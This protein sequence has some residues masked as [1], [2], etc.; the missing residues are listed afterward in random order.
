MNVT[1]RLN[2][3]LSRDMELYEPQTSIES[4]INLIIHPAR[5]I[6]TLLTFILTYNAAA[7]RGVAAEN[8]SRIGASSGETYALIVGVSK[9]KNP[10]IPEL[11]YADVDAMVFA[12]YLLS[13]GV[14]KENV[15][16]LINEN[17]TNSSFW[18]TLNFLAEKVVQGDQLY[19]YF[20]GHGDVENKTI[21][22]DAYLLPYDSPFTVYP[23]GAIG[24][25]YLKS[26]IA[27]FS[28]KGIK[29]IFIADAC[30]SGNLIGGREGMEATANILKDIW[31][32]EIKI[33]SCQPGELSLEGDQWGGGRGLFSYELI[34]GLSGLAD[35]DNDEQVSLRELNLYLLKKVPEQAGKNPQNP[36]ISG[37]F[38]TPISQSNKVFLK[39]NSNAQEHGFSSSD[40]NI[41]SNEIVSTVSRDIQQ[42]LAQS[43]NKSVSDIF[44]R[45]L[46]QIKEDNIISLSTP[47][48]YKFYQE[49]QKLCTDKQLIDKARL[50]LSEKLLEDVQNF[51]LF[52]IGSLTE[53][54]NGKPDLTSMSIKATLLRELLGDRKIKE[55]GNFAKVL[56]AESCRS[57]SQFTSEMFI[58]P[59][60]LAMAKLDSALA[61]DQG[62]VFVNCLKGMILEFEFNDPVSGISEYKKA[63]ED[64][65]N[66]RIA[67]NMLLM[68]LLHNEDYGA[69]LRYTQEQYPLDNL[70]A[71]TAFKKLKNMDS[72]NICYNRILSF[73]H[74]PLDPLKELERCTETGEFF[75][76]VDNPMAEAFLLKALTS[77][78]KGMTI[79]SAE[80]MMDFGVFL[81][82]M[83]RLYY[84]LA[85]VQ[86]LNGKLDES[87]KNLSLAVENG[88]TDISAMMSDPDLELV[89]SSRE[90]NK[91]IE[92]NS[93]WSYNTAC[94]FA[95][96]G[97]YKVAM[98]H[99]ENALIAGFNDFV[100]MMDDPD[101]EKIRLTKEFKKLMSK[102]EIK[103]Q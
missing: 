97:E 2:G 62:A 28:S 1:L 76:H 43:D 63:L 41:M 85:C 29:T 70:Y 18:S 7:Q 44:N 67:R 19:I 45:M 74:V 10:R 8:T 65:P 47:S 3:C 46:V 38:E 88:W 78:N 92:K 16:T 103:A 20:S 55:S 102:Y 34:N 9:Y 95:K 69:I 60:E 37:N 80:N 32:D 53:Q 58:M 79:S 30:R 83:P 24:V 36:M 86:S 15:H 99:L 33:V 64:N 77:L 94:D 71:Y 11:K 82:S 68:R 26:W 14:P 50:I 35:T 6:F 90:F 5:F 66:F 23:M 39:I 100:W 84:N 61:Y 22:Q 96:K 52:I 48:A 101:L 91:A 4:R 25:D 56:F 75:I 17:A 49:L 87:L 54:E 93:S 13:S 21:V 27:T 51:V 72:A 89:R 12:E 73:S 42:D 40:H 98:K 57:L 81:E 31:Q 59:K